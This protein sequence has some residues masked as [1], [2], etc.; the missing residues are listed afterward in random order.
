MTNT[1]PLILLDVDGPL[2]PHDASPIPV[3]FVEHQVESPGYGPRTVWL[4]VEHGPALLALAEETGA[5]LAWC[6]MWQYNASAVIGSRIGLPV[7]PFVLFD[8]CSRFVEA[9]KYPRVSEFAAGRPV[10]WFDDEFAR[11]EFLA[12]HEAFASARV[13]PT[14]LHHVDPR[15]GLTE[16]DYDAARR[17]L[18][19][20]LV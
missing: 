14:L 8:G 13:E 3:G 20:V 19:S 6:S 18:A 1:C 11:P 9:W 10:V 12:A 7:M 4:N 2:S 5:E 17:F 16:V 15:V